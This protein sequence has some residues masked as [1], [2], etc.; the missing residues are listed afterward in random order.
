MKN[1]RNRVF[2]WHLSTDW[3]QM[4]IKNIVSSE[5]LIRVRRLLRALTFRVPPI[6][7][8][9]MSFNFLSEMGSSTIGGPSIIG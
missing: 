2:D 6:R 1:V 8:E 9:S 4:A 7:C 3:R 5:F